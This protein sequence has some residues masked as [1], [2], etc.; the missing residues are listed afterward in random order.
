M[1]QD[2]DQQSDDRHHYQ[3]LDECKRL[4][5]SHGSPPAML[6]MKSKTSISPPC[7][8]PGMES[9]IA[10]HR[11]SHECRQANRR[12]RSG[13]HRA[14]QPTAAR[15]ERSV[16]RTHTLCPMGSGTARNCVY[17]LVFQRGE[18]CRRNSARTSNARRRQHSYGGSLQRGMIERGLRTRSR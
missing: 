5:S 7:G 4:F 1:Q 11:E 2:G 6:P 15:G 13:S 17:S 12:S 16:H 3:Q 9:I 8:E 14:T 10:S 18:H